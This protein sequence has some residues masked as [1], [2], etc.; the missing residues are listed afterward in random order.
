MGEIRKLTAKPLRHIIDTSG[1]ADRVIG[2]AALS[3]LGQPGLNNNRPGAT[4]M[5]QS[6]VLRRMVNE[7]RY[8]EEDLPVDE[9]FVPTKDFY[10][11]GEAV[12]MMHAP[13]AHT[14]GDTIVW[15]RRSD[16]L[17]VGHLFSPERYPVI[18]IAHGGSVKGLLDALNAILR[19]TVPERLQ[20]GGTRVLPAYGRICNEAEVVEYREMVTLVRDRI[21][22][23]LK[24]GMTLAQVKAA[25]P[26]SDY[27]GTYGNPDAFVEAVYRS[28]GGK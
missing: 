1:D 14:D 25:K 7:A 21:Q 16:V 3:A 28:L 13:N 2:N 6:N 10:F 4:V 26:S 22:D 17:A 20:D 23:M 11:N 18:D 8:K 24:R 12:V 27:D 19:I 9:Y 5:A 15:F